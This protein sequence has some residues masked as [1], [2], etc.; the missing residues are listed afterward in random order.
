VEL[1]PLAVTVVAAVLTLICVGAALLAPWIS[2]QDP[3]NMAALPER[4][5]RAPA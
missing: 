2:P 5:V 1:S 4:G 3:F